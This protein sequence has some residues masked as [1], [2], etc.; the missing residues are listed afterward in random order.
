MIDFGTMRD[1]VRDQK[2]Y[3]VLPTDLYCSVLGY[4]EHHTTGALTKYQ[5]NFVMDFS[6]S[7]PSI[8]FLNGVTGYEVFFVEDL[9]KCTTPFICLNA[10]TEG[11]YDSLKIG[12]YFIQHI[13]K[14]WGY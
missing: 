2:G 8:Q 9:L 6:Y 4:R 10:G 14:S 3:C 1:K 12:R 13:L 11:R 7:K 5:I